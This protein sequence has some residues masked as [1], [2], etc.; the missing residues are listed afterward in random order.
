MGCN[1]EP[2]RLSH[3]AR[4]SVP[5]ARRKRLEPGSDSALT[6]PIV[7][8]HYLLLSGHSV[9]GIRALD[10]CLTTAPK[11][12]DPRPPEMTGAR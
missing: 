9:E 10:F 8:P 5:W 12:P 2:Y 1:P 3:H 4:A 7:G 6:G 11:W